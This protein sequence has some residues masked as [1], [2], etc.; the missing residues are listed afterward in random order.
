MPNSP[1]FARIRSQ[2]LQ[3]TDAIPIGRVC[4]Y[5]SIGAHLDVEPRHVAYILARLEH[6]EKRVHPWHRVVGVGGAL[7]TPKR[8]PDGRSQ[9]DLLADEGLHVRADRIEHGFERAF[10]AAERLPSGLPRQVRPP[11]APVA[12]RPRPRPGPA[13]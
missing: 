2:V 3:L 8:H 6:H 4:T 1:F 5:Q 9:A 10:V 7:G 11:D 12:R 13:R